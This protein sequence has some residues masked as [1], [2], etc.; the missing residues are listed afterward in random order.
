M[1]IPWARETPT[2]L[3]YR[4]NLETS[5]NDMKSNATMSI[6]M[7]ALEPTEISDEIYDCIRIALPPLRSIE[8]HID[9]TWG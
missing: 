9:F 5:T 6:P 1:L 8:L 3:A 4:K 2:T 7:V